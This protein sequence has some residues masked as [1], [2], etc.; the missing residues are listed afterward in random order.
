[1]MFGV[2]DGHGGEQVAR[3]CGRHL[4]GEAVRLGRPDQL[5]RA[6]VDGFHRMDD[7]LRDKGCQAELQS[8]TNPPKPGSR[9]KPPTGKVDLG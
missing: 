2:F 4:P 3:F 5:T 8:C 1:M 9:S 6:L 7:M